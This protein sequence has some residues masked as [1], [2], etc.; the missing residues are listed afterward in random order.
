MFGESR[1]LIV[2]ESGRGY[3]FAAEIRAAQSH[4]AALPML[5]FALGATGKGPSDA[6]RLLHM[7]SLVGHKIE[8]SNAARIN[9]GRRIRVL[10]RG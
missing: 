2:T 8:R 4:T 6:N 10:T 3:R 5:E 9:R 7:Y 1:D